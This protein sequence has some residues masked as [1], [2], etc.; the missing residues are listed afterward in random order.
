[1][2]PQQAILDQNEVRTPDPTPYDI[3]PYYVQ[4]N[5][6]AIPKVIRPS[7]TFGALPLRPPDP[8]KLYVN[9]RF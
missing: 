3:A 6:I 7:T 8:T 1:M 9:F 5:Y 2:P 4:F